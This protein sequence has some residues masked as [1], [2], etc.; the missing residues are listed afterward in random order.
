MSGVASSTRAGSAV[1]RSTGI[2]TKSASIPAASV[3]LYF[4]SNVKY[5]PFCVYA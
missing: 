1:S 4:S 5:A 3:P 2:T